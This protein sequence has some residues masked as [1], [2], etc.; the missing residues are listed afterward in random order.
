MKNNI[1]AKRLSV[2]FAIVLL[3]FSIII[4]IIFFNIFKKQTIDIQKN[5]LIERAETIAEDIGNLNIEEGQMTGYGQYLKS[6]NAIAGANAWVVD[7]DMNIM[8]SQNMMHGQM[9]GINS[10]TGMGK[11]KMH[12]Q[13][14]GKNIE[15][16]ESEEVLEPTKEQEII[17]MNLPDDTL[18]VINKVQRGE[19][20]VSQ[21]FSGILEEDSITVGAPIKNINGEVE[22]IVLLHTPVKGIDNAIEKGIQALF[23][24]MAIGLLIAII[25]SIFLSKVFTGPILLKEAEDIIKLEN[26]RKNFLAQIAHEL[27]TPITVMKSSLENFSIKENPTKEELIQNNEEVLD[28]VNSMQRLVGDLLDLTKLEAPDFSMDIQEI[29][30]TDLITD[31]ERSMRK[32]SRDRNIQ[33]ISS[34]IPNIIVKGDYVRLRQMFG[35]VLNN[36]VK[37][38]KDNTKIEIIGH[39]SKII[40]RDYG[41]GIKK[42]EIDH[43]FEKFYKNNSEKN[44]IGTGLGLP[45]AKEIANR[46]KIE[47]K[48]ESEENIGTTFIFDLKNIM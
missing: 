37:F 38:S 29:S 24:S 4:G 26:D 41:I 33:I 34:N 25:L 16:E 7:K 48:V 30:I 12:G 14:H 6:I 3:F 42:S 18:K 39:D 43:I 5:L 1:S 9:H 36:A 2:Y 35:I 23:I 10:K 11:G 28:E 27:K 21:N 45:I 22:K 17:S 19:L 31:I 47:I 40:I 20:A 32:F 44:I 13:M 8:T 46:H 15:T